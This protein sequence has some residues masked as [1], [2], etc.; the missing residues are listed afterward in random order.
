MLAVM[1]FDQLS[2]PGCLQ[3]SL[4]PKVRPEI[5]HT[6]RNSSSKSIGWSSNSLISMNIET[7]APKT[8]CREGRGSTLRGVVLQG[9]K[10]KDKGGGGGVKATRHSWQGGKVAEKDSISYN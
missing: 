4:L 6:G 1:L 10:L 7:P 3:R 8:S 5:E 9:A 2:A